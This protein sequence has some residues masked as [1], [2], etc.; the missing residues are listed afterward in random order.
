MAEFTLDEL[1]TA[2]FS[3]AR[4]DRHSGDYREENPFEEAIVEELVR[5]M[6]AEWIDE[7]VRR[8]D[9]PEVPLDC[10]PHLEKRPIVQSFPGVQVL[11]WSVHKGEVVEEQKLG[12]ELAAEVPVWRA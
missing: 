10:L 4:A 9:P 6:G 2:L 1:R 3:S 5:R 12:K 8:L 7:G 11:G